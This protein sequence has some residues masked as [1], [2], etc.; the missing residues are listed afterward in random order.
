MIL[1]KADAIKMINDMCGDGQ[2]VLLFLPDMAR[3]DSEIKRVRGH[4]PTSDDRSYF[5]NRMD[6]DMEYISEI[7]EDDME[8][9]TEEPPAI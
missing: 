6:E 7:Q 2:A 1:G 5:L 8:Y 4:E 9:W 3:L